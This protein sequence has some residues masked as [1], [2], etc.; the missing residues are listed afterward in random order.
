MRA[1]RRSAKRAVSAAWPGVVSVA[2]T[3]MPLAASAATVYRHVDAQGN[4]S[5]SDRPERG[6]AVTLSPLT[7]VPAR[8]EAPSPSARRDTREA[9]APSTAPPFLPYSTFRIT[10]PKDEQTLPTGYAGNIQ[11]ELS[12]EPALRDDHRIRLLLDGRISQSA[13][14]SEVFMLS[15]LPRGE[16]QISAEL[17]DADGRVRHRSEPVTLFVQRASVNLPRN[18]NNPAP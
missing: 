7:V 2:L 3:L 5:Y 4:V 1:V 13:L 18:P 15:N 6:E 16:H 9:S 12:V 11:V 17:L 8:P 14:H 10:T